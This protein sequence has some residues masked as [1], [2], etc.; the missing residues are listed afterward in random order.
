[1]NY[2][3]VLYKN[4]P[5]GDKVAIIG[6][7]GIGFDMAEYLAHD[8]AHE[9]VSLNTENYMKE[10]GVDMTYAKGGSLAESPHSTSFAKRNLFAKTLERKAWKKSGE[11]NGLDSPLKFGH[12]RS[13]NACRCKL[14]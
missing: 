9:S 1:M 2:V 10:W 11:N 6:S 3:D 8:M 14:H 7:G 13:E 12:E 5:V 4:K